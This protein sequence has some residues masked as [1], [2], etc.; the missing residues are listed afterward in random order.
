MEVNMCS[1]CLNWL[2]KCSIS[3]SI[4]VLQAFL[5]I[6]PSKTAG[7]C[8]QVPILLSFLQYAQSNEQH[9][10]IKSFT[11]ILT[12]SVFPTHYNSPQEAFFSFIPT[13]A[14]NG[15]KP[16]ISKM[17]KQYCK[18]LN[19]FH[20]LTEAVQTRELQTG[21]QWILSSF[22]VVFSFDTPTR[23]WRVHLHPPKGKHNL[24]RISTSSDSTLVPQ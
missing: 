3:R 11:L 15:P 9:S 13:Y 19:Q 24:A 20:K 18:L 21:C 1:V 14:T 4:A 12:E 23:V 10:L 5:S 16:R 17:V 6:G 22:D 7:G 8:F 2:S